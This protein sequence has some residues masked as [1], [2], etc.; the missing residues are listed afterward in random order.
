MN[1]NNIVFLFIAIEKFYERMLE[2][3]HYSESIDLHKK[4]DFFFN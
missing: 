3:Q 4:I 1:K 2:R